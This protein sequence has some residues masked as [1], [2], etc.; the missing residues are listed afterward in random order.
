MVL[1]VHLPPGSLVVGGQL[2][3]AATG[4]GGSATGSFVT[5]YL[6]SLASL[7]SQAGQAA[8]AFAQGGGPSVAV[9]MAENAQADLAAQEFSLLVGK[10][11]QAYQ[12]IMNMQV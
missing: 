9:V 2:E 6:A 4:A 11:L 12:S 10:A 7:E 5:H 1:P 3:T 8:T